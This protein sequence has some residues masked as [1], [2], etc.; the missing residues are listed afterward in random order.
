MAWSASVATRPFFQHLWVSW[1]SRPEGLARDR[2]PGLRIAVFHEFADSRSES[3]RRDIPTQYGAFVPDCLPRRFFSN[4]MDHKP[5][6]GSQYLTSLHARRWKGNRRV[7]D[8]LKY[9]QEP[10]L[11]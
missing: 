8:Y 3:V 2:F 7:V 9:R 4:R 6:R 11:A 10:A 5:V 1:E